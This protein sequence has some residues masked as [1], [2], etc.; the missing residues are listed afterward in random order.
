MKKSDL[1]F[2]PDY[3]EKYINEVDDIEINDALRLYGT[4]LL[5]NY[6]QQLIQTGNKIYAERQMDSQRDH[7]A[8][9]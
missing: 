2:M 8:S 6:R 9:D 3:F 7:S 5:K 4:E 1:E